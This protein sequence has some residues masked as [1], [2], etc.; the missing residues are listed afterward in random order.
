MEMASTHVRMLLGC[1]L[2]ALSACGTDAAG[3]SGPGQLNVA[4]RSF[5]AR[6]NAAAVVELSGSGINSV[7]AIDGEL[8]FTRDGN[9]VRVIVLLDQPGTIEFL[10]HVDDRSTPPTASLI[11][12]AD[13]DNRLRPNSSYWVNI[14]PAEVVVDSRTSR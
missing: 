12:V 7:S 8:F 10:V 3:P 6:D 5:I 9:I 4:L 14:E 11:E 1:T 2:F 13:S